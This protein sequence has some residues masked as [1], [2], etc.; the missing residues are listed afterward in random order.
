MMRF[1]LISLFY[2]CFSGVAHAHWGHVGE[3][4]GHGHWIGI[5][6]VVAAGVIAG[7]WGLIKD[8]EQETDAEATD[9]EAADGETV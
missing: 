8:K 1:F 9:E 7:V 2:S 3:V 5:G 6:A 4:A